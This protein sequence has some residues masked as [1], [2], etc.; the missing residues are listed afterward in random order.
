[1]MES[2]LGEVLLALNR[3]EEAYDVLVAAEKSAPNHPLF[4]E[5]RWDLAQAC[6]SASDEGKQAQPSGRR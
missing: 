5:I 6:I 4:H 1:M 3:P 2:T